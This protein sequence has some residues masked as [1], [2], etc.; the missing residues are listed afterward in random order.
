MPA[1]LTLPN[2]EYNTFFS[3]IENHVNTAGVSYMEA[4]IHWAEKRNLE[5][6]YVATLIE[7][8]AAL[9]AKIQGEAETLS[10]LKKPTRQLI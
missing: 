8:N 4:I 10:F 2:S 6:E 1:G 9:K 7:Q 3:D 5:L